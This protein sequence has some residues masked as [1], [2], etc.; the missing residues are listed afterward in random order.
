MW[1]LPGIWSTLVT[2]A[3]VFCL[4]ICA[5]MNPLFSWSS[6]TLCHWK[7][8][9]DEQETDCAL[10]SHCAFQASCCC[11]TSQ[12]VLTDRLFLLCGLF[13]SWKSRVV[14]TTSRGKRE[15]SSCRS[16]LNVK[17][18][19]F[20]SISPGFHFMFK[21]LKLCHI[22]ILIPMTDQECKSTWPD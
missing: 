15:F 7:D 19:I 18:P 13:F 1:S 21:W 14:M 22:L 5:E 12:P 6:V 4:C 11:S 17:K 8:M 2:M 9:W 3:P 20:F 16:F 10:W